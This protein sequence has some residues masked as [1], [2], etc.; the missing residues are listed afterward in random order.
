M[1]WQAS[2][3]N[4]AYDKI[5]LRKTKQVK[6]SQ[7]FTLVID[8]S[9]SMGEGE[10]GS[11]GYYAM[12]GLIL[13]ME[14]LS[15]L[16]IDFSVIG[17][18]STHQI[19]KDFSQKLDDHRRTQIYANVGSR[20]GRGGTNDY[21][22]LATAISEMEKQ[23]GDVRSIIVLTDG[24][25]HG[26]EAMMKLFKR[27]KRSDIDVVGMGI[28]PCTESVK[29]TYDTKISKYI[30][31]ADVEFVPK[32]IRDLLLKIIRKSF[33]GIGGT[34]GSFTGLYADEKSRVR[35]LKRAHPLV[36]RADRFMGLFRADKS[37]PR[38]K[39]DVIDLETYRKKRSRELIESGM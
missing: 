19:D 35:L 23:E 37:V 10:P 11:S 24:A 14:A 12:Q 16:D 31:V 25:G 18:H 20:M 32:E 5:W 13:F 38:S 21:Q 15:A 29:H 33:F 6:R 7:K 34:P 4:P 36:S 39:S 22:A 28:G 26:R 1:Q 30:D 9:G 27:A 17:F 2:N 3:Y 8:L